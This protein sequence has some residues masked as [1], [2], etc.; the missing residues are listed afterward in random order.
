MGRVAVHPNPE[1]H[2]KYLSSHVLSK[3]VYERECFSLSA[4]VVVRGTA[5]L[6]CS[7]SMVVPLYDFPNRV[8]SPEVQELKLPSENDSLPNFNNLEVPAAHPSQYLPFLMFV[9]RV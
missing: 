6:N 5:I 2:S 7:N 3:L 1:H 4:E 8:D 9:T